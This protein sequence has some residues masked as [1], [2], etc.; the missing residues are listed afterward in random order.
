MTTGELIDWL[1]YRAIDFGMPSQFIDCVGY[2]ND[3]DGADAEIE[4]LK[5][6]LE[7][8]LEERDALRDALR[9][10]LASPDDQIKHEI[11]QGVLDDLRP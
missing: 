4:T 6:D 8:A 2:L 1:R 3:L 7:E 11:A 5:A 9:G 10:L